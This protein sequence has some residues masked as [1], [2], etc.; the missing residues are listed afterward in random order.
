MEG[1]Y[2]VKGGTG[3]E[4]C[5]EIIRGKKKKKKNYKNKPG[6]FLFYCIVKGGGWGERL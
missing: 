4:E 3:I 5:K 6:D 1:N 2:R